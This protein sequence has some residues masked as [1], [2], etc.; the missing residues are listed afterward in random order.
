MVRDSV[1]SLL[2]L[3]FDPWPRNFQMLKAWPKKKK[4]ERERVRRSKNSGTAFLLWH[5][6]LRI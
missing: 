5:S 4:K 1:L 2:W 6:R 3:G